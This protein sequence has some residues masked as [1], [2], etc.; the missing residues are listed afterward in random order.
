MHE[1]VLCEC[2]SSTLA[3]V[4][5]YVEEMDETP[6]A[7]SG[8]YLVGKD[9]PLTENV[10]DQV[11]ARM[12][13]YNAESFT[14]IEA[15]LGGVPQHNVTSVESTPGVLSGSSRW[16][17][18]VSSGDGYEPAEGSDLTTSYCGD[19]LAERDL[20]IGRLEP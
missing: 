14:C 4:D 13:R 7:Q 11:S 16:V 15:A 20:D 3:G 12:N 6:R 5:D 19:S 18:G 2:C 1:A 9:V 8:E 17:Q 10:L